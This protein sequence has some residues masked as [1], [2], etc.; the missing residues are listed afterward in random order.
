MSMRR[1]SP[2]WSRSPAPMRTA[3][4]RRRHRQGA[5]RRGRLRLR[6]RVRARRALL[7]ATSR[8][9]ASLAAHWP[10]CIVQLRGRRPRRVDRL[11]GRGRQ[12]ARRPGRQRAAVPADRTRGRAGGGKA[13]EA[14]ADCVATWRH[15]RIDPWLNQLQS[16]LF[17][18]C[19]AADHEHAVP[20]PQLGH[21]RLPPAGARRGAVYGELYRFLPVLARRQGFRVVE[22]KVRHRE[23]KGRAGFYGRRRLPAPSARHP[24]DHVPDALHAAPAALLRLPRVRRDRDR[25]CR[26]RSPTSTGEVRAE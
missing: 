12:G 7:A 19:T 15:S 6:V 8:N 21:A 1:W 5:G 24:R 14:G 16:R 17:N 4:G 2:W 26:L 10:L 22:V 3:A 20:R 9:C 18:W 13:L 11:V 25:C 23:E